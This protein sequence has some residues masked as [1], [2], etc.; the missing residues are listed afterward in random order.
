MQPSQQVDPSTLGP[1]P[2]MCPRKPIITALLW[3]SFVIS[4][5]EVRAVWSSAWAEFG[6]TSEDLDC[7]VISWHNMAQHLYSRTDGEAPSKLDCRSQT[8]RL[9]F[10]TLLS[11]RRF[12]YEVLFFR[13]CNDLYV[14]RAFPKGVQCR[15]LSSRIVQPGHQLWSWYVCSVDFDSLSR[16]DKD[17]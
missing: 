9:P 13:R 16:P 4:G 2:A 6:C 12:N 1:F 10:L 15:S 11:E 3:P 17:L 7:D 5:Q 14:Y 8:V